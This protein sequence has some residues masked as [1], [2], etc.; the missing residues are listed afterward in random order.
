[1]VP[2]RKAARSLIRTAFRQG[3]AVSGGNLNDVTAKLI[4]GRVTIRQFF[5]KLR[6]APVTI[7]RLIRI[8]HLLPREI[9]YAYF[10]DFL[11]NNECDTR[12]T[13]VGHRAFGFRRRI[14]P[15]DFRASGSG[16]IDFDQTAIDLRA[17]KISHQLAYKLRS[18]SLCVDFVFDQAKEPKI[19]EISYAYE[20]GPIYQT[21][22]YWDQS[23]KRISQPIWPQDAILEDLLQEMVR[24][25]SRP[26]GLVSQH[27]Q[28]I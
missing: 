12:I 25:A 16:N 7:R 21:G 19:V 27:V 22:G 14:R 5:D 2:D 20:P 24:K 13:V 23:L 15:N 1:L 9:G 18:Q 3:F 6:R 28:N 26:K 10:Q 11:P 4:S 8:N 17:V